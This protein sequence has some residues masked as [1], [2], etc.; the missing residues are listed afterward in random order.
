[1]RYLTLHEVI[2][3]HER[4]L[5]RSGGGTGVRDMAALE[6]AVAQPHMSLSG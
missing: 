2:W 6:S 5:E 1:M 3:L 4:V